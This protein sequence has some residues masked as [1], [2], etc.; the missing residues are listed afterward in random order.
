MAVCLS[1]WKAELRSMAPSAV[2]KS[3]RAEEEHHST[4]FLSQ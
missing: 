2:A 1:D 3:I 4:T